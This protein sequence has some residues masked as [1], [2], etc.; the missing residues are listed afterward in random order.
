MLRNTLGLLRGLIKMFGELC[1]YC[2]LEILIRLLTLRQN[3]SREERHV[4][5]TYKA[6]NSKYHSGV[7]KFVQVINISSQH[8]GYVHQTYFLLLEIEIYDSM[9]NYSFN[10]SDLQQVATNVRTPNKSFH[11]HPVLP[12]LPLWWVYLSPVSR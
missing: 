1:W 6:Y 5:M 7:S 3:V 4:Y 11:L 9:P 10:T 2:L 8:C 12:S